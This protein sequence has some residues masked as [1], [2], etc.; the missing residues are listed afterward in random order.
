MQ[1]EARPKA[2]DREL[3]RKDAVEVEGETALDLYH[4]IGSPAGSFKAQ[5]KQRGARADTLA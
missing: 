5:S 4:D 3:E 1:T 2:E